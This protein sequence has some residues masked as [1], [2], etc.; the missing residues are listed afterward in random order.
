MSGL[1]PERLPT[2]VAVHVARLDSREDPPN[3][4]EAVELGIAWLQWIGIALL[5]RALSGGQEPS[6]SLDI[7]L[8]GASTSPLGLP[9]WR[10]LVDAL[11]ERPD[12]ERITGTSHGR[13]YPANH[14]LAAGYDA[15]APLPVETVR[16]SSF[17]AFLSLQ[18]PVECGPAV[19][20]A[21][22][23]L[24]SEA[25]WLHQHPPVRIEAIRPQTTGQ[26]IIFRR[27]V[28][29]GYAPR[30]A[31]SS[32]LEVAVGDIGFWDGASSF[33]PIPPWLVRWD[34]KTR[35]PLIFSGRSS[36]AGLWRYVGPAPHR[37]LVEVEVLAHAPAALGSGGASVEAAYMPTVLG[38]PL[39]ELLERLGEPEAPPSDG[40]GRSAIPV[41]KVVAGTDLLRFVELSPGAKLTIGRDPGQT[42]LTLH[43]GR[44]SRTHVRIDVDGEG[45]VVVVDLGSS[46]GTRVNSRE[47]GPDGMRIYPGDVVLVGPVPHRFDVI[48]G[49]ALGR[50][51]RC[52]RSLQG[53][54]SHL[55]T[56]RFL[57][58]P[59]GLTRW[60]GAE[61]GRSC[62]ALMFRAAAIGGDEVDALARLLVHELSDGEVCVQ[63][64]SHELLALLRRDAARAERMA[65]TVGGTFIHSV[66]SDLPA[67]SLVAAAAAR[68]AT[69]GAGPWL[70]RLRHAMPEAAIPGLR[71]TVVR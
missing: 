35:Q 63:L 60:L 13:I 16:L 50:L 20:R 67:A 21:F 33:Q 8:R 10:L 55:L 1:S 18:A 2:W 48:D 71:I 12:A 53:A 45:N 58:D 31:S 66:V 47:V 68:Q 42:D 57:D 36:A 26:H 7:A 19:A 6:R 40:R 23:T 25:T 4:D 52:G 28:G 9:Q 14:P 62:T 64:G 11:L 37:T 39:S 56:P 70:L 3:V 54:D 65:Q 32:N 29:T 27:L 34:E 15:V 61:A 69:E 30:L 46:N 38:I 5:S 17:L 49:P 59:G 43:H 22:L 24:I 41:L 51:R 44:V